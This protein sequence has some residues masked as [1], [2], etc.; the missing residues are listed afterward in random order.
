MQLINILIKAKFF[1]DFSNSLYFIRN[2]NVFLNGFLCLNP[3]LQTYPNDLIQFFVHIK[4][5]IIYK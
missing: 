5:Y 2:K 1:L 3:F 4:Y